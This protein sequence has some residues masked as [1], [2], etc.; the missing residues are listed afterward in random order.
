MVKGFGGGKKGWIANLGHGMYSG[1]Y[2][3]YALLLGLPKADIDRY[4]TLGQPQRLKIFLR[5]D[6]SPNVVIT[7][8]Q[9][10]SGMVSTINLAGIG[11]EKVLFLYTPIGQTLMPLLRDF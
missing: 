8:R 4:Y 5:R 6:S 1:N 11:C 10:K 7:R 3:L 9:S 2:S